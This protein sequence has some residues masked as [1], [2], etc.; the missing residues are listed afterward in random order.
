MKRAVLAIMALTL[1]SAIGMMNATGTLSIDKALSQKDLSEPRLKIMQ[2][3]KSTDATS[4]ANLT[5][6][7]WN[8]FIENLNYSSDVLNETING[9]TTFGEAMNSFT[10]LFVLNSQALADLEKV[11]PDEKYADFQ[12]YT[13]N[14]M[15]YFNGY[16]ENMAKFFETKDGNYVL[17]ARNLFNES[18]ASYAEAKKEAEFIF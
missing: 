17:A 13:I 3:G 15:T 18:Q 10:S 7:G 11:K 4:E 9:N 12:N 5:L 14:A 1:I 2:I 16:L 6:K 8:N